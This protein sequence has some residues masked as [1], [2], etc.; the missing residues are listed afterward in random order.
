MMDFDGGSAFLLKTTTGA[1][2]ENVKE[3]PSSFLGSGPS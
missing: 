2:G 3:E 1:T